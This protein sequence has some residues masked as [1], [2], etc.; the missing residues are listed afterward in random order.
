MIRTASKF[1]TYLLIGFLVFLPALANAENSEANKLS[2]KDKQAVAGSFAKVYLKGLTKTH[3]E[4][5]STS[6]LNHDA[7]LALV[8]G[9]LNTRLMKLF[10]YENEKNGIPLDNKGNLKTMAVATSKLSI[11]AQYMGKVDIMAC[12]L[13]EA[14]NLEAFVG[15]KEPVL[16]NCRLAVY[17][18][19]EIRAMQFMLTEEGKRLEP[20]LNKWVNDNIR[21]S[22]QVACLSGYCN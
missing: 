12:H 14:Q 9:A 1:F 11:L 8:A 16:E 10:E 3:N 22:V 21:Y 18:D 17:G 7:I 5:I 4:L 6:P 20:T 15:G 19:S 2:I 13:K